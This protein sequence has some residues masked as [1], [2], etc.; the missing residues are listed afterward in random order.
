MHY[1]VRKSLLHSEYV[2]KKI[3]LDLLIRRLATVSEIRELPVLYL[4]IINVNGCSRIFV[5]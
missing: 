4:S 5:Q 1:D 3:S 2:S